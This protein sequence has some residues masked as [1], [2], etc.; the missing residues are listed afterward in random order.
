MRRRTWLNALLIVGVFLMRV[1]FYA[2]A[3]AQNGFY[4]TDGKRLTAQQ[5]V[6]K[7][8]DCDL[9]FFGE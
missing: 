1:S 8:E 5:V 9:I 7:L 2:E 4:Q 3:A 6:S